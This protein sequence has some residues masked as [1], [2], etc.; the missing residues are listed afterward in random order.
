MNSWPSTLANL[1][2]LL[3]LIR[4]PV[5]IL[6]HRELKSPS[7]TPSVSTEPN[8]LNHFLFQYHLYFH[9]NPMQFNIDIVKINFVITYL[10]GVVQN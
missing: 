2:I 10:T 9:T 3:I 7:L 8:K 1:L 5:L 4:L 6:I